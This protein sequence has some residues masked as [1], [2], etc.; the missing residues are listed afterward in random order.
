MRFLS[1]TNQKCAESSTFWQSLYYRPPGK[2]RYTAGGIVKI[3]CQELDIYLFID[4]AL[5]IIDIL[6]QPEI[7]PL[8][9]FFSKFF[10]FLQKL[11][12]LWL[13]GEVVDHVRLYGS[14]AAEG[15][16]AFQRRSYVWIFIQI[17][18]A[19][20]GPMKHEAS[21]RCRANGNVKQSIE[22][23][24]QTSVSSYNRFYLWSP[25]ES[26]G[27][28]VFIRCTCPPACLSV[29]NDVTALAL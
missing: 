19:V 27:I 1:P 7:T 16:S 9:G 5:S 29:S 13:V 26:V 22:Q 6:V 18:E 21:A 25:L 20:D 15:C 24:K 17:P 2:F 23:L 28:I 4:I 10:F 3:W 14:K 11:A 8:S 12:G